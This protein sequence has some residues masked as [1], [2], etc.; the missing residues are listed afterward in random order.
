MAL[1]SD[2]RN[3]LWPQPLNTQLPSTTKWVASLPT[4]LQPLSLLQTY[5]RIA[6]ALARIWRDEIGLREYF[7][8]LLTDRRGGRRGFPPEIH[9]ELVLLRAY[10]EGRYPWGPSTV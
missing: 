5:P 1:T 8:E 2:P 7:D 3:K 9:H 10:C 4:E 6:N